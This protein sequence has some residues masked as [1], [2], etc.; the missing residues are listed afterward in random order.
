MKDG[1][2]NQSVGTSQRDY[3]ELL[4]S[5]RQVSDERNA[6]RSIVERLHEAFEG[7]QGTRSPRSHLRVL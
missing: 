5:F 3:Q 7:V 1:Y 6:L 2:P 4:A